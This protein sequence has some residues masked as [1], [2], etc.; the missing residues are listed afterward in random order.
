MAAMDGRRATCVRPYLRT[1]SAACYRAGVTRRGGRFRLALGAGPGLALALLAGCGHVPGLGPTIEIPNGV[2]HLMSVGQVE[3]SARAVVAS[4]VQALGR[5]IR[6]FRLLSIRLVAPFERVGSAEPGRDSP[7][8][9]FSTNTTT[10][11]VLAEG[12]F[13]DCASTCATYWAATLVIEDARGTIVGRHPA[14]PTSLDAAF[15]T[16]R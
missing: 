16:S 8:M 1:A 13:R 15:A 2:A 12:T 11:V 14:G 5:Q 6:P 4:D 10:W 7:G 3:R 9:S